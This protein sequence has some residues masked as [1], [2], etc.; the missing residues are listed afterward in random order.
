MRRGTEAARRPPRNAF[1]ESTRPR[2]KFHPL[3]NERK[4]E[5]DRIEKE[6]AREAARARPARRERER[7]RPRS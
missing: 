6:R 1:F 2:Q 4:G 5:R 7:E 3:Y